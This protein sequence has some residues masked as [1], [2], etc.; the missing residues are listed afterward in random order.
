[1]VKD[2]IT[3]LDPHIQGTIK[4]ALDSQ[5]ITVLDENTK[6]KSISGALGKLRPIIRQAVLTV[7]TRLQ[8]AGTLNTLSDEEILVKINLEIKNGLIFKLL[9]D[10]IRGLIGASKPLPPKDVIQGL[11]QSMLPEIRKMILFE[12]SQWRQTANPQLSSSQEGQILS[13]VFGSLRGDVEVATNQLLERSPDSIGNDAVVRTIIQQFRPA[14]L[15]ALQNDGT[16][17]QVFAHASFADSDAYEDLLQRIIQ[18]LRSIILEQIRI[19]R[20][21]VVVT[22]PPPTR[23][24]VQPSGGGAITDIFGTGGANSV[25]VETPNFSY[26]YNHARGFE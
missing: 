26:E 8:A 3:Q 13:S 21:R 22:V 23:K 6:H 11:L 16:V 19:Y 25:Q 15:S 7:M 20:S 4:D 2:I 17:Q 9:E 24:P 12:I 1:M 5:T 18:A 10:E 14:I